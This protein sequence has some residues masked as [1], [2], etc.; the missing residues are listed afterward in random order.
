MA[1]I[2]YVEFNGAEHPI[3]VPNGVSLMEGA[4]RNGVPGIDGDCGGNAAC[5]TCHIHVPTDWIG[6]TGERSENEEAMLDLADGY[7][8]AT[9]RLAC[10]IMASDALDGMRV[11]MPATQH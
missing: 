8:A 9:S 10:Q 11:Q 2:T 6:R 5:A 7:D 3:D 1:I 4:V